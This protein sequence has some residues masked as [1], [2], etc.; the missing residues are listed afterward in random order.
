[1]IEITSYP[2]IHFAGRRLVVSQGEE[3][4][5]VHSIKVRGRDQFAAG[6]PALPAA[7]FS[8]ASP[9]LDMDTVRPGD[10]IVLTVSSEKGGLFVGTLMGESQQLVMEP[11]VEEAIKAVR[12]AEEA[13]EPGVSLDETGE[14][15][16]D[17]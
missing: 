13:Y 1:M 3:H 12:E 11:L 14:L 15:R 8:L 17:D 5:R 4:V 6:T 2:S 16:G 10:E 7:V 9:R